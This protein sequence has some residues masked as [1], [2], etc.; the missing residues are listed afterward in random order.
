MKLFTTST[1]RYGFTLIE[2]MAVIA[3]IGILITLISPAISKAQFQAKLTKEATKARA[4]VAAIMAKEA[5]SRFKR[6]WP[7][8]ADPSVPDNSTDFL[9]QLVQEGYLDVSYSY[10]AGPGQVPAMDENDFSEENN[11]WCIVSDIDD[12]TPGNTPAV[13]TRNLEASGLTFDD[14][15]PLGTKGFAFAT[16]NGEAITVLK[17]EMNDAEAFQAIFGTNSLSYIGP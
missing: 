14:N 10:F 11:M 8:S 6:G 1:R 4:I 5:S 15:Q 2:L 13:F 17:A 12:S 3:V 7:N 9:R 16:K